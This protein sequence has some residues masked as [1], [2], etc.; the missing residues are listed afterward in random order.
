MIEYLETTLAMREP[1]PPPASPVAS[2]I[3]LEA[4]VAEAEA[5]AFIASSWAMV[6]NFTGRTYRGFGSG[7]ILIKVDHPYEYRLPCFPYPEAVTAEI[8]S[9]QA[10]TW[11]AVALDYK[12]GYAQLYPRQLYR[13]TLSPTDPA[14][15]PANVTQAVANLALYQLIHAPTRREFRSQQH[16]DV[17]LTREA[18]MGVFYGSG[19]GAL[20]ASEVRK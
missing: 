2:D 17:S 12:A 13:L 9:D 19:A 10:R 16:G 7:E 5:Q 1:P 6:E 3:A 20:L 14:T 4:G 11:E 15:I 18:L 8:W